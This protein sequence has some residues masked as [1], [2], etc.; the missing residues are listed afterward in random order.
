M[1]DS[2][3]IA[4]RSRSF[5][6]ELR[7]AT[8]S[9]IV[10]I[11]LTVIKFLAYA[12]THSDAIFSDALENIANV[13]AAGFALYSISLAHRPADQEHPYG[14]GKIE[15]FSA[16]IEGGMIVLAAVVIVGKVVSAYMSRTVRQTQDLNTGLILMGSAMLANGILGFYLWRSGSQR[17]ALTL[18]AN[19]KHLLSDAIDSAAVL[20]ALAIIRITGWPWVDGVAAILVAVYVS[21]LGI[22]LLKRSASGLMDEQDITD[23]NLLRNI[24]DTHVGP[25]GREP[26]ICSYHKL[27]HRHAGRFHWVDF[28]IMI[29]AWWDIEKGHRVASTIEY[30]IEQAIGEGNATAHVEPCTTPECANCRAVRVAV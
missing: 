28:H 7:A 25:A 24:L 18:E 8:I 16:G 10:S 26:R 13:L 15:F 30:E 12:L 20:V 27:R 3:N 2:S 14:H 22:G 1:A 21:F 11:V 9:L 29:P 6:I 23:Q 4:D 5:G 17:N 19:G